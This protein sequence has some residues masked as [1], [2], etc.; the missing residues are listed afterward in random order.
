MK[1]NRALF[2]LVILSSPLAAMQQQ[3]AQVPTITLI[4]SE[5]EEFG[6]PR[7]IAL[8]SETL[9]GLLE[10]P[11]EESATNQ[12]PFSSISNE[13]MAD[14]SQVMKALYKHKDLKGAALFDAIASEVKVQDP[15]ALL[16]AA[17]FLDLKPLTEFIARLIVSNPAMRSQI[18]KM[19]SSLSIG[20]TKELARYYYLITGTNLPG[21]D[22]NSYGFSIQDYLDYQPQRVTANREALGGLSLHLNGLRLN[23]LD[24]LAN[25][26]ELSNLA[27]L[28]LNNNQLSN[29]APGTFLG[30]TNLRDLYLNNNQLTDVN[31]KEI[32]DALA[33]AVSIHFWGI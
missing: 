19:I 5:G 28:Y 6:V 33:P 13:T 12:I 16:Q 3:A 17:N 20:T 15:M 9:K 21:V 27:R 24:G 7:E 18:S 10:A 2:L 23:S 25:I 4:S 1:L 11:S 8:Q 32:R 30:L 26:Q 22:E 31:K 14:L 29:I